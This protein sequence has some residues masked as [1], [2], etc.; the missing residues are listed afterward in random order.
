MNFLDLLSFAVNT[1]YAII[2]SA[3]LF[4]PHIAADA[5]AVDVGSDK[6]F[7]WLD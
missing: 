6:S 4:S 3:V 2:I 5:E 7:A 1:P